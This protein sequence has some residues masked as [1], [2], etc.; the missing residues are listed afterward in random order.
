MTIHFNHLIKN[1]IQQISD[2]LEFH[3]N[4]MTDALLEKIN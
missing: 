3:Y 2:Q 4:D 1:G